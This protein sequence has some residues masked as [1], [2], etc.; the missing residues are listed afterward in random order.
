MSATNVSEF[1]SIVASVGTV[2]SQLMNLSAL[3][4]I[5]EIHRA[6]STLLYPAFPFVI[7]IAAA[8]VGLAY[9]LLS[10]QYVVLISVFCSATINSSF[11]LVHLYYSQKRSAIVR[12]LLLLLLADAIALGLGPAIGCIGATGDHCLQFSLTWIGVVCTIVYCVV[13][14][15][16][17]S[18]F[19]EV[20]RT[21]NSGSIS[22]PL[23][24]G[25]LF[26][27]AIWTWYSVLV[28]DLYYLTSSVV[29]DI[30]A[31]IQVVLLFSYPSIRTTEPTDHEIENFIPLN[32]FKHPLHGEIVGV[33]S[34]STS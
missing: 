19:R 31:L 32:V 7:A 25:T 17:L 14:C 2:S 34:G 27:V 28:M 23:T 21:K 11:L 20:I 13:Y 5:I 24:A 9:A 15:G 3:P 4:S 30:S 6:K 22:A 26:C 8:F 18:T 10:K 16:Q 1:A 29:G 33:K 12:S